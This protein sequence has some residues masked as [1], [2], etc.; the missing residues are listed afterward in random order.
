VSTAR[1]SRSWPAG[2][3]LFGIVASGTALRA[4]RLDWGLPGYNFP[5][6][7]MHFLR[8]AARAAAGGSWLPDAFVHPP[9]L[10]G[11]LAIA[12]RVWALVTGQTI[13]HPAL[14]ATEQLEMLTMVGRT[15]NVALAASSI[16]M[17]YLVAR[18]LVGRAGA[19]LAAAALALS[20]LHVLESHRLA[21]DIPALLLLLV[22]IH[23]GLM[24][25]ERRSTVLLLTSGV[26][27]GLATATRYTAALA[28]VGPLCVLARRRAG[29]L[30][31]L[32]VGA[33]T[34]AGF[35]V[36]CLPCLCRLQRFLADIGLIATL[37]YGVDAP[38]VTLADG[39]AQQRWVYPL[40][41]ALPY[42]MGWG[43][44]LLAPL[45][46]LA[47]W[48]HDRRA[49][50]LLLAAIVP[51][52]FLVGASRAAV[53]RYYLQVSPFLAI[54]AGAALTVPPQLRSA[55]RPHAVVVGIIAFAYTALI[56]QAQVRR[57]GLGPQREVGVLTAAFVERAVARQ[58]V[59]LVVAYP[60]KIWLHY[61]GVARFL[62]R[63]EVR[64]VEFPKSYANPF[65]DGAS[66]PAPEA[67]LA[68]EG[69]DAIVLPSWIENAIRR[70]RRSGPSK[71]FLSALETGTLGFHQVGDFRTRY[72]TQCLYTWGDPMLDTH[73]E[74]AIAGYRVFV[75]ERPAARG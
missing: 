72:P 69:V 58:Q 44:Y 47:L 3:L 52:V 63:P 16:V 67:W 18:R 68:A 33:A 30:V 9:V 35:L 65:V 51:Y 17:T 49:A 6:D 38:G 31:L 28:L 7:V 32:G 14:A 11:L 2:L 41:V 15:L 59:P 66:S 73:W 57:L 36:G 53:P 13:Q 62:R 21:P 74:T 1:G 54:A 40:A 4:Y 45:G 48:R 34:V 26:V 55:W 71:A 75:R 37:G 39:L 29:I 23:V 10:I 5:D 22:S 42:M 25:D 8:P 12:F 70:M 43:L 60:S 27:A 46:L 61:D 64:I 19:L 56:A 24:A 50:L 20:P